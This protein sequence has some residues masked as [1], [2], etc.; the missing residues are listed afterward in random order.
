MSSTLK[1]FISSAN[2]LAKDDDA[3]PYRAKVYHALLGLGLVPIDVHVQGTNGPPV[4]DNIIEQ[5]KVCD[6]I[7]VLA[8][9]ARGGRPEGTDE[10]E[11]WVHFE[12]HTAEQYGK[13]DKIHVYRHRGLSRAQFEPWQR[14]YFLKPD[15]EFATEEEL[16]IFVY[17]DFFMEKRLAI[18]DEAAGIQNLKFLTENIRGSLIALSKQLQ[19]SVEKSSSEIRKLRLKL[20]KAWVTMV[21]ILFSWMFS[22]LRVIV[23]VGA[24]GGIAITIYVLTRTEPIAKFDPG[25]YPPI[26]TQPGLPST[27]LALPDPMP[28]LDS[29]S[30][31]EKE[32]LT[33]QD[34]L[35]LCED[36]LVR[37]SNCPPQSSHGAAPT[38]PGEPQDM[39]VI[40]GLFDIPQRSP[41]R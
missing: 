15:Q 12:C 38:E 13:L 30:T 9:P 4:P 32:L 8:G 2:Q 1:V 7:I 39:P 36:A 34:Q 40:Q 18:G 24:V 22:A 35:E 37:Q 26:L 28:L 23:T 29:F 6:H 14:R 25:G 3:A 21:F 10:F 27:G 33:C 19:K 5:I 16:F 20:A 41:K 11:S 31:V 17:C